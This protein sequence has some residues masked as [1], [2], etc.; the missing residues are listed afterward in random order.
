MNL[1]VYTLFCVFNQ[2]VVAS[3]FFNLFYFLYVLFLRYIAG[4]YGSE[5]RPFFLIRVCAQRHSVKES[6]CK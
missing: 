1:N 2:C 4:E 5:Q 6:V 3:L